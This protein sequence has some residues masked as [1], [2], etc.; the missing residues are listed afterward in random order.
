MHVRAT[1]ESSR[2]AREKSRKNQVSLSVSL[3]VV[4]KWLMPL[5]LLVNRGMREARRTTLGCSQAHFH[6][7]RKKSSSSFF[8]SRSQGLT[9][10]RT[11][12]GMWTDISQEGSKSISYLACA[13]GGDDPLSLPLFLILLSFFLSF[14]QYVMFFNERITRRRRRRR[15]RDG[16]R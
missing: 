8:L 1:S 10:E 16:R 15:R 5:A 3:V 2:S 4:S 14:S 11:T 6:E 13:S 12:G 9:N 7:R